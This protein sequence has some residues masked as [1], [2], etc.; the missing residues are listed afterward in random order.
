MTHRAIGVFSANNVEIGL[1]QLCNLCIGLGVEQPPDAALPLIGLA[2]LDPVQIIAADAGMRVYDAKGL[3]LALQIK[4]N[5]RQYDVFDHI[6]EIAGMIGVAIVHGR[7]F[8]DVRSV[9]SAR[10]IVPLKSLML[11]FQ[12]TNLPTDT[13]LS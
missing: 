4:D 7:L 11:S 2:R 12:L 6:G 1:D 8:H 9:A 5:S 3:V 10:T 13:N